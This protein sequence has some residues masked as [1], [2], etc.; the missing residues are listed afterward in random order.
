MTAIFYQD[1]ESNSESGRYTLEARSPHNG[2]IHHRDGR[3][4]SEDEFAFKYR[5][6]QSEFRFRLLN[7]KQVVWERWQEAKEDAPG[8]LVVSDNGW[9]VIRTHGFRPEIIV[10]TPDGNDLIRV[11][12][13]SPDSDSDSSQPHWTPEHISCSTAGLYWA[14]HSWRYFFKHLGELNFVWRASWGQRLV[15]DLSR[16]VVRVNE[17][18]SSP[19]GHAFVEAERQSVIALLDGVSR[20]MDEVRSLLTKQKNGERD[21]KHPLL[22]RIRQASAALH[23][24]GIHRMHDSILYLREWES[25]DCPSFSTGSDAMTG[26]WWLE[27]QYFR[28][29][30]HHSLKLLGEEPKGF[31]TYHF[32]ATQN[33]QKI[34]FFMPERVPDRRIRA[35]QIT[36]TMSA[37]DVLNLVGSPDFISRSTKPVGKLFQSSENWE[38]D[39]RKDAG[40]VTLRI[41]WEK[42][43]KQ[44]RIMEFKEIEPYWLSSNEREAE[45]LRM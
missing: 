18:P 12:I 22:E 23:M 20:R 40:W 38:Y 35:T 19:F 28:P 41:T 42:K 43:K 5:Q 30:I 36:K 10:V 8:E 17:E 32:A 33:E 24:L 26:P 31:S 39:F 44:G 11:S 29:I 13:T 15:I 45:Y 6:H 21:E 2:T 4:V 14:A 25:L 3:K 1:C 9:T 34:R 7:N 16:A 37:K 27:A